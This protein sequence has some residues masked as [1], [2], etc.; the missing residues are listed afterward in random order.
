MSHLSG[1]RKS[2]QTSKPLIGL[3]RRKD[4]LKRP[5]QGQLRM[6]CSWQTFQCAFR[7]QAGNS[8]LEGLSRPPAKP[9]VLT[10]FDVADNGDSFGHSESAVDRIIPHRE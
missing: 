6:W 1:S 2:K 9:V 5:L 8:P 3:R 4:A 10:C 7:A